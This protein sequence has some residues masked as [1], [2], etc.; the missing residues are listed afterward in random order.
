M[1]GFTPP[2]SKSHANRALILASLCEG[3]SVLRNF[4]YCEDTIY[5]IKSLRKLGVKIE[6]KEKDVFVFGN[7]GKFKKSNVSL[8]CGNAGTTFRFLTALSILNDGEVLLTGSE[9]MLQRPIGDLIDALRQLEI[10]VES[11]NDYPP[12]KIIGGKF[13]PKVV[14]LNPKI[15][16]QFLSA[17]LLIMPILGKEF[18]IEVEGELPSKPYIKLTLQ[19]LREFGVKI[20]HRN[21]K[22]FYLEKDLKLKP[23]EIIIESDASS[24]TYFLGSAAILKRSI[25]VNGIRK[26]ST[27]ADIKFIKVLQKMGCSVYWGKNYVKLKGKNLKGVSVNMNEAPD[28]VPTLAVVSMFAEGKTRIFNIENLRYK[29]SDRI[30]ALANELR[31]LGTEVK[32]GKDFLEIIPVKKYKSA[33]I[34]TYNDHRIAMSFA[35]AQL[36]IPNVKVKNPKC[37]KKSFPNFWSEFNKMR[38]VYKV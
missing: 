14:K 23:A 17:L 4:P 13:S 7:G 24:A 25:K 30:S 2:G 1:F 36:K 19:T 6:Q 32:E 10:D 9:R 22:I 35:I 33:I 34:E 38:E 3:L 28:S 29:E 12:V 31:K 20:H 18:K 16:S 27:Q 5:M 11:K 26:N 15:S 37:V 21:F 8:Y